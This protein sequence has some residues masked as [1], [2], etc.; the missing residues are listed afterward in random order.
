MSPWAARC[1]FRR[2]RSAARLALVLPVH[3]LPMH[4]K[5]TSVRVTNGG[6]E[7]SASARGVEFENNG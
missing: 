1:R 6:F 5:V 3:D 7:V 2:A 4:L